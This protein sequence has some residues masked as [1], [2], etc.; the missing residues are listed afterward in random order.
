MWESAEMTGVCMAP[1]AARRAAAHARPSRWLS[2]VRRLAQLVERLGERSGDLVEIADAVPVAGEPDEEA[3]G[4]AQQG[5]A[6]GLVGV[7]RHQRVRSH[8]GRVDQVERLL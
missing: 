7:E 3:A 5:E 8:D 2:V 6:E 4:V 1:P